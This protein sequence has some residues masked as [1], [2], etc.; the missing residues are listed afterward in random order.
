ME[1]V[2]I[3]VTDNGGNGGIKTSTVPLPDAELPSLFERDPRRAWELFNERYADVIF[4]H[5]QRLGFDYDQAMD[6]FVYICEKLCEQDFRR[7]KSIRYAGRFGDLK[8][9]IQTVVKRLSINWAW[10]VN[11]RK[12]LLKPIQRLPLQEQRI[13]ELYFWKGLLPSVIQ[14]QIQLEQKQISLPEV[15]E[16]LEHIFSVLSQKKLWRLVSNL[17][18]IRRELSLDAVDDETGI[19]LELVDRKANPEETLM[20]KEAEDRMNRVLNG[21]SP[22]ERLLIQFRYQEGMGVKEVAEMLKVPERD[23]RNEL[24]SALAHLR[25]IAGSNSEI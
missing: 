12:R 24:K 20:A 11:G 1:E 4:S 8:P 3:P 5:L 21:L 6:R 14:E 19:G 7:L 2:G 16:G 25:A 10:S 17:V 18:R 22:R 13:F 15:F 9:W 23:V